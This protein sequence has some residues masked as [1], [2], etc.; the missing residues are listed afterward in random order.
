[1]IT[2]IFVIVCVAL[3]AL[4]LWGMARL[5]DH[6]HEFLGAVSLSMAIIFAIIGICGVI[7]AISYTD[8]LL[9]PE[10]HIEKHVEQRTVYVTMLNEISSLMQQDVTASDTY[11]EIYNKV[12]TFNSYVRECEKWG[13]T[14]LEGLF[15]DPGY[16]GLEIIPLN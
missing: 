10:A 1:M 7:N 9:N 13:G 12:I 6:G 15:C 14:W 2:Y 11:M 5:M 8:Y 4:S 16:T 3:F